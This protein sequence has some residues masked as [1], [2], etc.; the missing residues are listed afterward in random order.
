MQYTLR[1]LPKHLD[2]A[3]RER[4]RREQK[5]LNEVAIDALLRAFGMQ[6]EHAAQRDLADIAGSWR[7]DPELDA[8]LAEQRRVDPDLWR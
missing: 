3:I 7:E 6:G 5:S 4:A 2:R 1:N 8:V